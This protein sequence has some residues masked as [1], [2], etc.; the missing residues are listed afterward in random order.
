MDSNRL[1]LTCV[2]AL[3]NVQRDV[4]T[5]KAFGLP[6]ELMEIPA[7]PDLHAPEGS[8][9]EEGYGP[10]G[11]HKLGAVSLFAG[12]GYD[13]KS[14]MLEAL[15]IQRITGCVLFCVLGSLL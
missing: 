3:A 5:S 1:A 7:T 9:L 11:K 6:I 2:R 10:V 8:V 12:K 13:D 15:R 4:G 14:N